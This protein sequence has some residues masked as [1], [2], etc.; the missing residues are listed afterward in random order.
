[1]RVSPVILTPLLALLL[2]PAAGA[3]GWPVKPFDK[4]HP[5]RATF[6]DPRFHL[7]VEG[8]LSAFHF[9]VDIAARDGTAVY[10]VEPGVVVRRYRSSVTVG[11][12]SGRRFGYWHIQPVVRSG[13]YVRLHQLLGHIL[14]G[15]AHVHF[16]ESMR[17]AYRNP[18]RKGALAPFYDHTVPT[19]E[20]VQLL[21]PD[22]SPVDTGHVAGLIDIEASVYDIPPIAPPPPWDMARLAPASVWWN[23]TD[24]V[25]TFIQSEYVVNFE[26]AL[27]PNSLYDWIYAPGTYQ[28][29]PRRA[30]HYLFW[31]AHELDTT[32][33]P[34]GSYRLDI[35]AS[36]TRGNTGEFTFELTIANGVHVAQ[37]EE[38]SARSMRDRSPN[39]QPRTGSPRERAS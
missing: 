32:G 3:Y 17:G 7:D 39:R 21:T 14:P 10:A 16:A 15:W 28:N 23:L 22:G 1:M 38:S 8:A 2:A 19:I 9:G 35:F 27:P 34:N 29:K 18:L 12:D 31:L 6:G 24:T 37:R 4:P 26:S 25:G 36:D 30:G 11:R 20:S 5:I 13:T 33:L